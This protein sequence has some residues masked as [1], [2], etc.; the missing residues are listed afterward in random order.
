VAALD[1]TGVGDQVAR[2]EGLLE[3][4]EALPDR[5]ARE[6]ATEIVAA[7]LELYGEG[8]GRILE[9]MDAGEREALAG[10]ELV[11]HLLLLHNLHPV[12]LADRVRGALD[13][14]R[15]YLESHGGGVEL[16]GLEDGVVRLALRGSCSGCPSSTMTLKLAI[17][18]AIHKAAP[19]VEAIEAEGAVEQPLP[20]AQPGLIQLEMAGSPG[21]G[22]ASA[23][24]GG[25]WALAGGL[26]ELSSAGA[27]V[28]RVAGEEVLFARVGDTDYAYR[29]RC[30]GC[31]QTVEASGVRGIELT[32]GSCGRSFDLIRA[33]RCLEEPKLYLDPVPLLTSDAGIV[34]V[35]LGAKVA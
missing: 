3:E 12:S 24:P 21:N 22:A 29:P 10:D 35:A 28:K 4:L 33:G 17:E 13:E 6:T 31:E 5:V 34:K 15:P 25:E 1:E 7:L 14:V 18:D 11:A 16:V 32:C 19:D 27:I 2:V 30:P 23:E 20:P 9:R 26:P 8:L